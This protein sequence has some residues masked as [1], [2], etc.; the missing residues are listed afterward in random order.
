MEENVVGE[1]LESLLGILGIPAPFSIIIIKYTPWKW[2]AGKVWNGMRTLF[3][4]DK[5]PDPVI[6]PSVL[7]IVNHGNTIVNYGTVNY[8]NQPP[9]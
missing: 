6:V 5:K 7:A 9:Q 3:T 8:Y 1:T 2:L 4:K